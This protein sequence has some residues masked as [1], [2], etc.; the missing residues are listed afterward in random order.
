MTPPQSAAVR[1][2]GRELRGQER[3]EGGREHR[4]EAE[5]PR[6][7]DAAAEQGAHERAEVP[8]GE[9][10]QAGGQERAAGVAR[11]RCARAI[12]V[13]SSITSCDCHARV[14]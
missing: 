2:S 8:A 13:D 3:Q 9:D 5:R 7:A 12:A 11:V 14:A 1:A 6:V 4:V 10:A